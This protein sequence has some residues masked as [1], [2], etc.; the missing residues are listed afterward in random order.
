MRLIATVEVQHVHDGHD[1]HDGRLL[2][3]GFGRSPPMTRSRSGSFL[4]A[5]E[6]YV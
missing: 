5:Q 1:G 3:F 2:L 6:D 4:Q